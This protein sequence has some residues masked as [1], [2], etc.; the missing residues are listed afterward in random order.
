MA[1]CPKCNTGG[2]NWRYCQ[3]CGRYFC[4]RCANKDLKWRTV[5]KCPFCGVVNKLQAKQPQ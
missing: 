2:G 5:N 3:A 4:A 1:S